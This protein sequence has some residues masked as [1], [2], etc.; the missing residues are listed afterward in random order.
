MRGKMCW[1]AGLLLLLGVQGGLA[2]VDGWVLALSWHPGFCAGHSDAPDCLTATVPR[3]TLH[4][5][6]PEA[7]KPEEEDFCAVAPE[8]RTLDRT[9]AWCR[10][11]AQSVSRETS[12]A[13]DGVMPGTAACLDRHEWLRH[14]TCSGL[15]AQDYFA[16]A[17]RLATRAGNLAI[18]RTLVS[19]AGASMTLEDMERSVAADFGPD[20]AP[21]F[22]FVCGERD[23]VPYLSEVRVSLTADGPR[24]FP[25]PAVLHVPAFRT[26]QSCPTDQQIRID[27]AR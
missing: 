16:M 10:L 2:A 3:L 19:R 6:W 11:P 26:T 14:G 27:G 5:L 21:A 18:E 20:R 4:G 13:L 25:A 17:A 24:L 23:G 22:T 15:S 12:N 8:L 1:L 7:R 9:N